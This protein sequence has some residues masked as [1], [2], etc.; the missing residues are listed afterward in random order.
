MGRNL[1]QALL[2]LE[3]A[4]MLKRIHE[5]VDPYLEM[6]E[7][8]RQ[9]SDNGGPAL[10]FEK[11]KGCRFQAAA[12]IFGTRERMQFLFCDTLESTK[13]AI[14]FKAN[15]ARFFAHITPAKLLRAAKAGLHSLPMRYGSIHDFEECTLADL[16]QIVSWP[17]DGGAFITLPLVATRPCEKGGILKTNLG[18]YRIQ[19]SGN[20]YA[21]DE[22][23]LH[24]QI[25]RDIAAHHQKAIEEGRPLKVSIFI[26]GS[27]AHTVAPGAHD[28][29]RYAHARKSFGTDARGDACGQAIPLFRARRLPCL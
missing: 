2:D 25:N 21:P 5:E 6:A 8:A 20:D 10:L 22:C 1:R 12:N 3:Q 4:G 13:T 11:V 28:S 27:P 7:I 23:G 16:P 15:P 14:D 29:S 26:G 19:I 9:A 17:E 18:M 24:Y